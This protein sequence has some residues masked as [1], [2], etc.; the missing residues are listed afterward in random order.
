MEKNYPC[1]VIIDLLPSYIDGICSQESRVAVEE[2]LQNCPSC[3]ATHRAMASEDAGV[4]ASSAS[5]T[6]ARTSSGHSGKPGISPNPGK[7]E[8]GE[9]KIMKKLHQKWHRTR[10]VNIVAIAVAGVLLIALALMIVRPTKKLS[11]SDYRVTYTNYKLTD[12]VPEDYADYLGFTFDE[13]AGRQ[14]LVYVY[15]D[16][17]DIDDC[18]FLLVEPLDV[19]GGPIAVDKDYIAKYPDVCVIEFTSDFPM[20]EYNEEVV[21]KDG[22][23]LLRVKSVKTPIFGGGI[24]KGTYRAVTL[25]FCEI[26]GVE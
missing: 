12:M 10:V 26:D 23:N 25:E 9:E 18:V 2:H 11:K 3:K 4:S 22:K 17:K 15:E 24:Q 1:N 7:D 5:A 14:N 13:L 6:A 8:Q 20:V 16:G 21:E 19:T